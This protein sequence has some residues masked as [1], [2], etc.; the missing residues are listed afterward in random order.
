MSN[1]ITPRDPDDFFADTRMSFGDHIEDLR[2]HLLKAIYGFLIA[3]IAG[4]FIGPYALDF[5]KAPVE[6]EL[7]N[8]YRRRIEQASKDLQQANSKVA[9]LNE[10]KVMDLLINMQVL[11]KLLG[12]AQPAGEEP[13]WVPVPVQIRPVELTL[14]TG[15]AAQM[16]LLRQSE[17]KVMG[18]T[19]GLMVY[20]KVS[21]YCGLVLSG[22]WIFYQ[23]W[24]FIA[25]GLYPHEKRLVHVSMPLSIG[26]FL[27][28]IAL[29][30]FIVIPAALAYLMSIN[31][32]L[33]VGEELRLNEWLNF[34]IWTPLVFGIAFQAPVVMVALQRVGIVTVDFYRKQ[35]RM[36]YFL[37]AILAVPLAATPD[38][39]GM[40]SIAIPL[41]ILY[42]FGIWL[43]RFYPRPEVDLG[44]EESDELVG[45]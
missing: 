33:G 15:D 35:R 41:W 39:F 10:P 5:I 16:L 37:L 28:G 45:V 22:P 20:L 8:V 19:E 32:W 4:F 44:V 26:L 13:E 29:C 14:L 17:L 38:A 25:A 1:A 3:M 36:A 43:C 40:L 11:R 12:V 42:E 2:S 6:R 9:I 23:L 7:M 31:E 34:A 27:A 30:Q 18:A 24:M 21:I